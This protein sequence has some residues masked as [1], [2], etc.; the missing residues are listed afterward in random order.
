MAGRG[1]DPALVRM[2]NQAAMQDI[3]PDLTLI[4]DLSPELGQE[5]QIAAGKRQDRLDR[6]SVE[7]HRRVVGYYLAVQGPGVRHLD[8]RLAP[9]QLLQTAWSV[10][11]AAAPE[12]FRVAVG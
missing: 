9:D 3:V 12:I 8:G 1:L 11:R 6:E 7:F 10:V 2:A 4:L 5:R